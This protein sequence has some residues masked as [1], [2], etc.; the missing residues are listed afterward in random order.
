LALQKG[1]NR[2]IDALCRKYGVPEEYSAVLPAGHERACS[3]P[4]FAVS[5]YTH[6]LETSMRVPLHGFFCEVLGH[7]GVAPSQI[8][9]NGWRA[10]A[11]FVFR[12]HFVG[13]AVNYASFSLGYALELEDKLAARE[14][15]ADALRRELPQA[16]AE[17]AGAKKATAKEVRG[18]REAVVC[19]FRGST[20]Q[21]VRFSEHALAVYE[22]GMDDMKQAVLRRYPHLDPE[23]LVMPADGDSTQ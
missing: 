12:S 5:V 10:M 18:A 16:K 2:S 13:V 20:E 3:P 9:P 19:D 7:F 14:H 23:Q 22:K 17:L 8:A 4:G 21:V 6:A 15:E 1:V 11:S